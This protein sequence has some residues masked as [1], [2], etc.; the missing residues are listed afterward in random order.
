MPQK[1]RV[2]LLLSVTH[3]WHTLFILLLLLL[4]LYRNLQSTFESSIINFTASKMVL[5]F[6]PPPTI[7]LLPGSEP[8][9]LP[10]HKPLPLQ[11]PPI[12][13]PIQ[14]PRTP[15]TPRRISINEL[16]GTPHTPIRRTTRKKGKTEST[17]D[18]RLRVQ[19]YYDAGL[20]YKQIVD[21]TSLS[22][23]QVYYAL[24]HQITPQRQ[25]RG[26]NPL[27]NE[28][29]RKQLIEY[30][31]RNHDTRRLFWVELPRVMGWDCSVDAIA[32]AIRLEGYGRFIARQKPAL[33]DRQ[34]ALRLQWAWEHINWTQEQ[35]DSILWSDETWTKPGTHTR[36]W[37]T[38]KIGP[39]EIY[40][41][42]C[43]EPKVQRKI[44][45]MFWGC[46]SGKYGK[47]LG[48]FWEKE[49][50]TITKES[51]SIHIV[52]HIAE[53]LKNHPGLYFQQDNAPGHSA[54]FT[55]EVLES[56]GIHP[57]WWP[58]NSPDLAPIEGIW[59]EQKDWVQD[60]DSQ[61]HRNYQRL[62]GTVG[63]AWDQISDEIIRQYIGT[64]HER[65]QAVIDA[66][67]G[68]TKF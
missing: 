55:K 11:L 63:L 39:E 2:P 13:P 49:W 22:K 36:T 68:I 10:Q 17:R 33:D 56:F 42:D 28:A 23:D 1:L 57:I 16:L 46:I 54:G 27:L 32:T 67:G 25:K 24:N 45:W 4:F 50:G 62:R 64:M 60:L 48:I 20:D 51:Y 26:R 65:C 12:L 61:V 18:D 59:D 40:H 44:A 35:W 38:R 14:G 5:P 30:I 34:K 3:Q 58:P 21:R 29:Q 6:L 52:P 19:T 15:R 7:L 9:T 66:Q 8:I 37:I 43:L 31:S 47:G 41:P 53:Y